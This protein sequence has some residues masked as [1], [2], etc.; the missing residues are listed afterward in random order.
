MV[1]VSF[2]VEKIIEQKPFLQEALS[3]NIVNHAALAEMLI[4]ELQSSLKKEV[5]FSAVNMAIRRLSEKLETTF[6]PKVMFNEHSHI[7]IRSNL[8][9]ITFF[10]TDSIQKKIQSIYSL[11]DYK[12]G[13][14]LTVTQG[15]NEVMIITDKKF[16]SAITKKF[17]KKEIKVIIEDLCSVTINIPDTAIETVG[18]FYKIT[19]ALNWENIN[20]IEVISTL[21]E[22]SVVLRKDDTAKAFSVLE[23]LISTNSN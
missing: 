15:L 18:V 9:E 20:I 1:T 23:R 17:S 22:L 11:I 19:R 21:T 3:K 7:T 4:P 5:K 16:K 6:T 2:L 8:I 13:D 12:K 14:F 10:K